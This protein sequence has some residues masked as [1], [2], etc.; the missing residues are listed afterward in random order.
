[1]DVEDQARGRSRRKPLGEME[2]NELQ[3]RMNHNEGVV[4][5]KRVPTYM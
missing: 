2:D 1:M 4:T 3:V 5:Y